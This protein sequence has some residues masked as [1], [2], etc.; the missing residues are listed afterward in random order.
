MGFSMSG[1]TRAMI[2]EFLRRRERAVRL[3]VKSSS[4]AARLTLRTFSADTDCWLNT[5]LTVA[6]DTPARAATS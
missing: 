4:S 6:T 2:S 1:M 5:R 3:G